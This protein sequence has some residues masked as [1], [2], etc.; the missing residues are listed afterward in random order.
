MNECKYYQNIWK[1]RILTD[2]C[3]FSLLVGT[4]NLHKTYKYLCISYK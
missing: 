1:Y 2:N 4:Y 3:I